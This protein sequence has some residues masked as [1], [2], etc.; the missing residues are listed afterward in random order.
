MKKKAGLHKQISSIFDGVPVPKNVG[1]T[2]SGPEPTG[3]PRSARPGGVNTPG[4]APRP[5]PA[6]AKPTYGKPAPAKP[7]KATPAAKVY[8]K[9]ETRSTEPTQLFK[10]IQSMLYGSKDGGI[11]SKQKTKTILVGVLGFVFV[12]VI[13]FAFSGSSGK[14]PARSAQNEAM[15]TQAGSTATVKIDWAP[16]KPWPGHLRDPMKDQPFYQES[17][18]AATTPKQELVVKG[19]VFSKNKSSAIVNGQ[20]VHAGET[21][22]GATVVR[23]NK[24]SVEFEKGEKKWTQKTQN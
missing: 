19:I 22:F 5:V 20:I 7:A 2:F 21:I 10:Q 13:I 6:P 23:I 24:S 17:E 8:K 9:N 4:P 14:K 12:F 18:N 11:D 15:V 16:P 3:Q 1:G